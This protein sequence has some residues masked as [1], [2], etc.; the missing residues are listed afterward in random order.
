MGRNKVY[1]CVPAVGALDFRILKN[2][3]Q[4]NSA[5]STPSM[6]TCK[7]LS[8]SMKKKP[9]TATVHAEETMFWRNNRLKRQWR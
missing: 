5:R 6:R 7:K 8:R 9:E 3:S 1:I 4:L 2:T